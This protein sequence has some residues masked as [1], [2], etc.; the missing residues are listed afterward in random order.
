[1]YSGFSKEEKKVSGHLSNGGRLPGTLRYW[2]DTVMQKYIIAIFVFCMTEKLEAGAWFKLVAV[3]TGCFSR[4]CFN[5]NGYI[6]G[7]VE[8]RHSSF[9]C[10]EPSGAFGSFSRGSARACRHIMWNTDSGC[11]YC[12]CLTRVHIY[13]ARVLHIKRK[14][15]RLMLHFR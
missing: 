2:L 1:M 15:A 6:I 11:N 12:M 7:L 13:L 3:L 10:V 9:K 14:V 4:S 5:S 8:C